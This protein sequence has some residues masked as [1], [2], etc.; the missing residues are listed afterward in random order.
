MLI[1]QIIF[2]GVSIATLSRRKKAYELISYILKRGI[3]SFDTAPLYSL[4][5]S[6]LLLGQLL[7][8][9]SGIKLTSKFGG[10]GYPNPKANLPTKLVMPLNYL[11]RYLLANKKLI[12]NQ[13]K[14]EE[15]LNRKN[16]N[17]KEAI[18]N[19]FNESLKRLQKKNIESYL[20]HEII[21]F[22]LPCDWEQTLLDLKN[23]GLVKQIGYG[24]GFSEELFNRKL[25]SW[26][27]IMQIPFPLRNTKKQNSLRKWLDLNPTKEIRFYGLFQNGVDSTQISLAKEFLDDFSNTK[28]L[29][30]CRSKE[31]FDSN[32]KMFGI[33]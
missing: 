22:D 14:T 6:E 28:I 11:R 8:G 23:S 27:T 1:N 10:L 7:K 30:S 17:S 32:L 21:P 25:P 19:P 29:F 16:I 4:G 2:G 20:L 15:V 12:Q 13:I 3:R 33:L 5:Y 18:I 9:I 24:G 31:R 26:L